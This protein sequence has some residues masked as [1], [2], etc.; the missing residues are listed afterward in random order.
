MIEV[1]YQK[2]IFNV[3]EAAKA[4][5]GVTGVY[6]M[7]P[8]AADSGST[9]PFPYITMGRIFMNQLDTQTENG[10]EVTARIH[11]FSRTGSML[12]CK[13][14]QGKI[15]DL[16]HRADLTVTGF[17]SFLLLRSDT[18]CFPDQDGKVHGVCEY[19]GLVEVA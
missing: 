15:Y 10:F 16:L 1:E 2:A 7:A 12:Q 4:D 9:A 17:N 5:L 14:I 19:R 8:Q 13:T 18:D 11:T 3:L 6:D